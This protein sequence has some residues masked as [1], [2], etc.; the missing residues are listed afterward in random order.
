MGFE[1][2][3]AFGILIANIRNHLKNSL[4]KELMEHGVSPAQSIILRRLCE[5][6]NLNQ[7]ELAKDT[8]FKQPS[9]TRLIDKLEENGLVERRAKKNDRRAYLICITPKGRKLKNI[10]IEANDKIEKKALEGLDE[11]TKA[12]LINNLKKIYTNLK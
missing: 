1:I 5:K 4:E 8:F 2:D 12:I 6:D 9:L 11:N 3:N 7:K 10:L